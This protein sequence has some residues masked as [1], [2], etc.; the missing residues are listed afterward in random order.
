MQKNRYYYEKYYDLAN[1]NLQK[2]S[3]APEEYEMSLLS[4]LLRIWSRGNR[5]VRCIE[6]GTAGF[7]EN[8]EM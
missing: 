4:Y 7:M 3:V 2:I 6:R 5:K 1:K 8:F